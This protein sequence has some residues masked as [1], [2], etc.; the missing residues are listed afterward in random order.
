VRPA[1]EVRRRRVAISPIVDGRSLQPPAGEMLAGL[2]YS[3]DVAGVARF[4]G[5]LVDALVIDPADAP[6]APRV[7]AEGLR[8]VIAPAVMRD[9][10]T[11]RALAR[12]TLDAAGA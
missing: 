6:L 4:Y 2:G 9:D 3:V 12:A 10:G 11:R 5:G 7:E 8:A 1:L